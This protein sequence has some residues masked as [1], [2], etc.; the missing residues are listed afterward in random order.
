ML[1]NGAG[2]GHNGALKAMSW[3]SEYIYA[4]CALG[5][6]LR[7]SWWTKISFPPV[8]FYLLNGPFNPRIIVY[9][10]SVSSVFSVFYRLEPCKRSGRLGHRL[11]AK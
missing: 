6:F 9:R 11:W 10:H 1:V 3:A 2:G 5:Q 8:T 4:H 7:A